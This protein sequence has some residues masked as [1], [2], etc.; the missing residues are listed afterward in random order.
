MFKQIRSLMSEGDLQ[1]E[2]PTV[3][4]DETYF[5]GRRNSGRGRS[6]RGDK[7][8]TPIVGIVERKGRVLAEVAEDVS[9][10]TLARHGFASTSCLTALSTP[11]NLFPTMA[12]NRF[13]EKMD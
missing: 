6:M 11:M 9:G 10:A 2:G 3:E 13:S 4:M 7:G 8:T 12:S 5:D 1:L